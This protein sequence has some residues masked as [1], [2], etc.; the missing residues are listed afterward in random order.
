[1]KAYPLKPRTVITLSVMLLT[2]LVG[3]IVWIAFLL[4]IHREGKAI[5]LDDWRIVSRQRIIDDGLSA[6]ISL[7]R[8]MEEMN[9]AVEKHVPLSSAVPSGTNTA[10][11][12]DVYRFKQSHPNC[13]R[14]LRRGS[15]GVL[16]TTF[17]TVFNPSK[18]GV[19]VKPDFP[20]SRYT[21]STLYPVDVCDEQFRRLS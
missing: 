13:C 21:W 12:F 20:W 1:M 9:R 16:W 15:Q 3:V 4:Q 14:I 6:H 11:P 19:Y 8:E 7:S 10:T 18:T 17:S 5:C 2:G